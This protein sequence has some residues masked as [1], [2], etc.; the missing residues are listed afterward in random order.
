MKLRPANSKRL[1]PSE[2]TRLAAELSPPGGVGAVWATPQGATAVIEPRLTDTA[3][4]LAAALTSRLLAI[5][6]VTLCPLVANE[7]ATAAQGWQIDEA[8]TSISFKID[9]VGFPTTHGHFKHYTGSI[10]L[11]LERPAKSYTSF[12]VEAASVDLGSKSF[13]D[14][15]KSAALLNVDKYPTMSFASTLIEK[16]DPHT[17]RVTGNLTMIGVTKPLVLAVN[18]ETDGAG[19]SRMVSL[20]AT[21]KITRSDF[22]MIFG[23]PIID[24]T[25]EI[26]VKTRALG[27]E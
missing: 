21:G 25:L 10:L 15:V 6:T 2:R 5:A 27:N 8:H 3:L 9:A 24:D 1:S 20:L 17:A 14:F 13:D 19:K 22:G 18:V 26:T 7:F 12:S 23:I 4:R 16:L 11:D